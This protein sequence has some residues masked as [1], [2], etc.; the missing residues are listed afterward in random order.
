MKRLPLAIIVLIAIAAFAAA[1]YFVNAPLSKF[2]DIISQFSADSQVFDSSVNITQML[3]DSNPAEFN[4]VIAKRDRIKQI[5]EKFDMSSL[6]NVV[7][8]KNILDKKESQDPNDQIIIY[9]IQGAPNQGQLTYLS[10]KTKVIDQMSGM[11]AINEVSGYGY[12]SFF[13]NDI[14][15]QNTGF[16]LTQI[17]DNL[18]GFQYNKREDGGN[19]ETIKLMTETLKHL[20]LLT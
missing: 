1:D 6:E 20:N 17:K 2:P 3:I 8:F 15:N 13:Y 5:F 7:I 14:N 9:E 12:N 10:L 11:G 18:F 16:L 4:Y 19:F